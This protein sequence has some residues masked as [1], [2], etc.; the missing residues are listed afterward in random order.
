M[1]RITEDTDISATVAELDARD[2]RAMA[3]VLNIELEGDQTD[4]LQADKCTVDLE[5]LRR[6]MMFFDSF[7]SFRYDWRWREM[8]ENDSGDLTSHTHSR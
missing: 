6:V 7:N 3:Y 5:R 2:M 8:A 4:G 1:V